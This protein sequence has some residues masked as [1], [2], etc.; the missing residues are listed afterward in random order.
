M[1]NR[2]KWESR[3]LFRISL[4]DN[5]VAKECRHNACFSDF[6]GGRRLRPEVQ[7]VVLRLCCIF[8][9]VNL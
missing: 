9:S 5:M 2:G 7:S 6:L 1:E 4:L 3:K 8:I